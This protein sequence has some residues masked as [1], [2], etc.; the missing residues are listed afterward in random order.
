L[1]ASDK[2]ALLAPRANGA[3]ITL[4]VQEAPTP[5]DEPQLLV[6]LKSEVP[7]LLIVRLL[8]ARG[9]VPVLVKVTLCATLLLPISWGAK[10]SEVAE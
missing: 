2:A 8:I 7:M 6:W 3:K 4:M 5:S 10:L 1:L 9:A